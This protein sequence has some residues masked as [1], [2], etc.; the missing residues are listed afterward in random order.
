[1]ALLEVWR[2]FSLAVGSGLSGQQEEARLQTRAGPPGGGERF[3]CTPGASQ[4]IRG[5]FTGHCI[6]HVASVWGAEPT[7]VA[8]T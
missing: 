1:M 3:H 5:V 4:S 6:E 7:S 2:G 8:G